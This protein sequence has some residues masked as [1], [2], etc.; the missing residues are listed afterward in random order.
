M[1]DF[2][3][4]PLMLDEGGEVEALVVQPTVGFRNLGQSFSRDQIFGDIPTYTPAPPTPEVATAYQFEDDPYDF[5][6]E[7]DDLYRETRTGVAQ[8][9]GYSPTKANPLAMVPYIGGMFGSGE[10]GQPGTYDAQGN[11]FGRDGRA[12]DPITGAPAASFR[13]RSDYLENIGDSYNALSASG[14][15]A[16]SSALGSYKNSPYYISRTERMKGLTPAELLGIYT[17]SGALRSNTFDNA[18]PES[19]FDITP[20]D[21]GFADGVPNLTGNALTGR[22]GTETG[23]VFITADNQMGVVTDRGSIALPGGGY[24]VQTDNPVTG[25]S[26]SLLSPQEGGGYST[27]GSG[28]I[29]QAE[30]IID[31]SSSDDNYSDTGYDYGGYEDDNNDDT[32]YGNDYSFNSEPSQYEPSSWSSGYW[33]TGGKVSNNGGK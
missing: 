13:S 27:V 14:E 30:D 7:R 11:V 28:N 8:R 19:T 2:Y 18:G 20:S 12:Y 26:I 25:E 24:L 6:K 16:I 29:I 9:F 23:D 4:D 15:G 21:L 3:T 17:T 1:V 33:S 32:S 31:Y 22:I 5:Q 10:Y